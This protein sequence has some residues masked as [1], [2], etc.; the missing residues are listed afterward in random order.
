M[1]IKLK[2]CDNIRDL[3][4]IDNLKENKIIRSKRL[5]DLEKEEVKKLK[6]ENNLK[7]VIDLRTV[8]EAKS[9]PYYEE[10]DIIY[11]AIPIF[12]DEIIGLSFGS[13]DFN[14][15]LKDEN[16]SF[17]NL[18][19]NLFKGEILTNIGL[20]IKEIVDF[21]Y[22]KGSVLFHCTQGKDRTGIIAAILL[23]ILDID[24]DIIYKDYLYTN[25]VNKR[26]IRRIWLHTRI[27]KNKLAAT[28]IK[29]VMRAEKEYL[30]SL[31][32]YIDNNFNNYH[33]FFLS[34]GL[35]DNEIDKFKKEV[36]NK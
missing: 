25:I 6:D 17:K 35:N 13:N 20:V 36:K 34:L 19:D 24:K 2:H 30:D 7:L 22:N 29:K 31:F 4:Y 21:D 23:L 14:S 16:F 12:T 3:G 8:N 9:T 10:F 26:R 27:T 18:Y 15:L 1:N 28:N 11:K 5:D 32:E 33:E